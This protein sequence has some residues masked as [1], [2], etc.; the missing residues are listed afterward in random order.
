MAAY[1]NG[2][3][4]AS[5]HNASYSSTE[6]PSGRVSIA[7]TDYYVGGFSPVPD[8]HLSGTA[9]DGLDWRSLGSNAPEKVSHCRQELAQDNTMLEAGV[10]IQVGDIRPP[11]PLEICPEKHFST[12]TTNGFGVFHAPDHCASQL[13]RAID[14]L[15]RALKPDLRFEAEAGNT[16]F[17]RLWIRERPKEGSVENGFQVRNTIMAVKVVDVTTGAKAIR[18]LYRAKQ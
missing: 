6:V 14:V 3:F 4:L 15:G 18:K 8:L 16:Y 10:P 11:H 13:T 12:L 7:F 5:L 1:V 17:V 9:C 2:N